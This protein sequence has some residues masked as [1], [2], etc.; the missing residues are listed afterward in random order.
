MLNKNNWNDILINQL[1]DLVI[2][3]FIIS[4][5]NGRNML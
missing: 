2:L 5:W 3:L 4:N 1:K